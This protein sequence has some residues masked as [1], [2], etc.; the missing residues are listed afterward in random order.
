MLRETKERGGGKSVTLVRG[1]AMD[2][3][4]L[5][6]R[7]LKAPADRAARPKTAGGSAGRPRG[8]GDGCAGEAGVCG[9]ALGLLT[10]GTVWILGFDDY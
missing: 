7:Q 4:S 2:A 10:L 9:E 5:A 8:H 6:A 3:A 1:L